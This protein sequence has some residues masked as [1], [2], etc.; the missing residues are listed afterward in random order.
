M[1]QDLKKMFWCPGMKKDVANFVYSCLTCQKSKIEHQ[2]LSGL[3]KPLSIPEWKWN[4]ICIN[5]VVG[6][7]KT[8]K[9]SYLIWVVMDR[10]TKSAHFNSD[11]DQLP[12][13]EARRDL[14]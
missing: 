3:V 1:N 4:S 14:P 6:L 13:A 11:K 8:V 10:L 2:K 5:F 12:M 7:P 9:G